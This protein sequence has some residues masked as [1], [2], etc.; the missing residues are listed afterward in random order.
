MD[1]R[2]HPPLDSGTRDADRAPEGDEGRGQMFRGQQHAHGSATAVR[3]Q[4]H[5]HSQAR[6]TPEEITGR[7][8]HAGGGCGRARS[9][10][11]M[12][13]STCGTAVQ[14]PAAARSA[15]DEAAT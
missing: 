2:L 7:G 8:W 4:T 3:V 9:N 12:R 10:D 11:E 14:E 6:R 1:V 5:M 15:P 13:R